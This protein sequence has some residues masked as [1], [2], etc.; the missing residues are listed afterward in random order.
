[1]L[2]D[3]RTD[4]PTDGLVESEHVSPDSSELRSEEGSDGSAGG[5]VGLEDVG[6]D[7][8][9]I[10]VAEDID[11]ARS[12]SH[13]GVPLKREKTKEMSDASKSERRKV[14]NSQRCWASPSA[15][16][17]TSPA[18]TCWAEQRSCI[19]RPRRRCEPATKRNRLVSNDRGGEGRREERTC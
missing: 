8:D 3:S 4:D 17:S 19:R 9:V 14:Q 12:L 1:L 15:S 7:L 10:A 5:D 11:V 13:E 16:R 6:H 2:S 18:S